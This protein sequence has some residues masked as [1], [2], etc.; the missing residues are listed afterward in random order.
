MKLLVLTQSLHTSD[1]SGSAKRLYPF[2]KELRKLGYSITILSFY[3]NDEELKK[4]K[5]ESEYYDKIITIKINRK[6]AYIRT[7]KASFTKRP[8]K[9]EF[10]NTLAMKNAVK[11]ELENNNYD[12]LYAHYYKMAPFIEKYKQYPRVVDLCDA[13]YFIYDKQ[14]KLQ[15]N[16]IKKFFIKQERDRIYNYEKWCINEFDKCLY[17]SDVDRSFMTDSATTHK[18]AVISN[19]VDSEYFY[20]QSQNYNKHEIN[21]IGLMSYIANHDAVMHF[22]KNIYP[23]I[24]Q[25]VPD[26]TFKIIGKDPKQ[27]LIDLSKRDSSIKVT[28]YVEN[29]RKEIETSCVSV[30]PVR[31]GAGIQN[32]ILEAMSMGIPVVTTPFGAEG[33]SNN[34]NILSIAKDDKDFADKVSGI[35]L[36]EDKRKQYHETVREF[37]INNFSWQSNTKILSEILKNTSQIGRC[38]EI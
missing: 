27:E 7:L 21:Y 6:L 17:I 5:S 4:V 32:K 33:I 10:F 18:T 26:A 16:I 3:T 38:N 25:K 14:L 30:A 13:F 2:L 1:I 24:K 31:I 23:L 37:C 22:I 29:I 34:E 35:L 11:K 36:N 19:G 28:G 15:K 20:L 9:L 12:I 8:F